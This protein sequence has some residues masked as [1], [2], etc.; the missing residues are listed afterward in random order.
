MRIK[1]AYIGCKFFSESFLKKFGLTPYKNKHQP[2][3][4]FGLYPGQVKIY[5]GHKSFSVIVFAGS[6]SMYL[7]KPLIR[8]IKKRGDV[9]IAISK[10]IEDDLKKAGLKY[11]SLPITPFTYEGFKPEPLGDS[12]YVY[13]PNKNKE[14]YGYDKVMEIKKKTKHKIIICD[15]DTYSRKQI[16]DIYKKCFCGIRLTSHDGMSNT[17]VELGLMGRYVIWNGNTP[18][19]IN[20]TDT[21]DILYKIESLYKSRKQINNELSQQMQEFINVGTD[22]MSTEY[23]QE[24][25]IIKYDASVIINTYRNSDNNLE[26]AIKSYL[27]QH[28]VNMQLIISTVKGDSSIK[29]AEKYNLECCISDKPGIYEQLNKAL[30]LI[31]NDYFAYASGNDVAYPNKMF[32]EIDHCVKANKMVCYSGFDYANADLKVYATKIFHDYNYE[33]HL[34]GNFV[35]D[36]ATIHKSMLDKYAPFK[37]EFKNHAYWDFWLRIFEGEGNVFVYNPNPTWIYRVSNKS[38]HVIRSKDEKKIQ[39]NNESRIKMLSTHGT[40]SRMV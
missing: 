15:R 1:Q 27:N 5:Y 40:K 35:N 6:D 29:L 10:Y 25:Q 26:E 22:W 30:S 33:R 11:I 20:Y 24:K 4:F 36:C 34:K 32:D 37:L 19:A 18:N 28:G 38:S 21:K 12:I 7:K 8:E 17:V 13:L 23:F 3:I 39:E 16:H 2:T 9:V 31:K 14:I